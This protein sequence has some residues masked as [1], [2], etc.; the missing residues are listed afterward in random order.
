MLVVVVMVVVATEP[1]QS[2][3]NFKESR[4]RDERRRSKSTKI[5]IES[6]NKHLKCCDVRSF[7]QAIDREIQA[8]WKCE[9]GFPHV[10]NV[11]VPLFLLWSYCISYTTEC[12]ATEHN[13][14]V[15]TASISV[16]FKSKT[17]NGQLFVDS[18][19]YANV[20]HFVCR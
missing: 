11:S 4:E 17:A 14:N 8:A 10:A 12:F 5:K 6:I 15:A 7:W 18:M 9:W 19:K 16:S 2:A 20:H 13:P 1:T 3:S